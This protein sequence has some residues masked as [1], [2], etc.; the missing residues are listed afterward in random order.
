MMTPREYRELERGRLALERCAVALERLAVLGE[1]IRDCID[2]TGDELT[3]HTGSIM[4]A[5]LR[6]SPDPDDD[7]ARPEPENPTG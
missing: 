2:Q 3:D 4:D 6:I 7:G 5:A 1:Q